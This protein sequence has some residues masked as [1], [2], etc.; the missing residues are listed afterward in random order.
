MAD[1]RGTTDRAWRPTFLS[2]QAV[3]SSDPPLPYWDLVKLNRCLMWVGQK[4]SL[5]IDIKGIGKRLIVNF[6]KRHHDKQHYQT[7]MH[8]SRMRTTRAYFRGGGCI[9]PVGV[10]TSGRGV[11][12]LPWRMHHLDAPTRCTPWMYP[13]WMQQPPDTPPGCS[14]WMHTPM[15][16]CCRMDAPPSIAFVGWMHH[17][18]S[19]CERYLPTTSCAGGKS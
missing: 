7:S 16:H 6:T 15:P 17:P 14:P 12:P 5:N 9:L 13:H 11:H 18:H 4:N 8:S 10:H 2:I 1:S 3:F 19:A